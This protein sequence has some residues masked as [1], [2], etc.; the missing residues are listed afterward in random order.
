MRAFKGTAQQC[1]NAHQP[2]DERHVVRLLRGS[3]MTTVD[4]V[5]AEFAAA[6]QFPWYFGL[7]WDAMDECLTDLDW[8]PP[9]DRITVVILTANDILKDDPQ[10]LSTLLS[11]LEFCGRAWRDPSLREIG[12]TAVVDFEVVLN[13]G[14]DAPTISHGAAEEEPVSGPHSPELQ[15]GISPFSLPRSEWMLLTPQDAFLAMNEYVWQFSS[16]GGL[17]FVQMMSDIS[18]ES[19]GGPRDPAAWSDWLKSVAHV[20]TVPAGPWQS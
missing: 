9:F 18:I 10:R 16:H 5:F 2:V 14:S 13:G 1:A 7:N 20:K 15:A 8:L 6:F 3:R 19:D 17:D 4:G 11:L 12:A